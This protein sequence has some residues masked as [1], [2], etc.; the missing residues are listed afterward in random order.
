MVFGKHINKYYIKYGWMLL[1]GILS[2]IVVDIGQLKLPE[3]Y[4]MIVNG[5]NKG[6]VM[7]DGATLAFDMTFLLDHICRPLIIVAVLMIIGRFAW[8]ICFFGSAIKVER[9]LRDE[10]FDRLKEL[11]QSF[12]QSNKVGDLM[13]LFTNDLDTVQDSFGNGVL[14]FCDALFLGSLA[15]YKM[16]NMNLFLT[17]LSMIPMVIL[18]FLGSTVGKYMTAKWDERQAKFSLLS[19]FSQESFSGI[20]VIKAFAKETKELLAFKKLNKENEDVNVEYTKLSTFLN[21]LVVLFVESV[22]C[23]ILGY[24]GFLV[25]KG[26]FDAG[27]MVEFI[28]YFS[29]IVW[30]IEAIA[31]IVEMSSRAKASLKR[32]SELLDAPIDVF[33]DEN[34]QPVSSIRGDIEFRGLSFTHPGSS[35]EA[36]SDVSFAIK[37]GESVGIVGRTGAGK[38]TIADIITRTYNVER[39][40]VFVDQMD[41]ND[42]RIKDLRSHIAYVPQDNFLF[43]ESIADNIAFSLGCGGTEAGETKFDLNK[44]EEALDERNRLVEEAAKLADI[45]ENVSEFPDKFET[46]LGERGVTVSGG[47]KQRIAIARALLKEAEILILDDSVSAVDTKTEKVIID[48]LKR[49]RAGKTTLL[50]AHRISIVEQMDK[51]LFLEEG[52]V[53]D[54]GTPAELRQ[55]CPEYMEMVKLQTLEDEKKKEEEA[56]V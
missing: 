3:F 39:G 20:A 44:N 51:I 27:E 5:M 15:L 14:S 53:L 26:V 4:R 2:L 16:L 49:I 32:I 23:V 9:D 43:S 48:N 37:A 19:D 11:S 13:S 36:L 45:Y 42:I 31:M 10:M 28:G 35:L 17:L 33:D 38:T 7:V 46:I 55:R 8:R 29:A 54:F 22:I 12:Y 24:G 41:V 30:P 21:I 56:D 18:F 25:Y 52:R 6:E 47:Q 40:K 1:L 34:A 50:V